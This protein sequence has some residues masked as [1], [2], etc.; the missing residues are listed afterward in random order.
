MDRI[1]IGNLLQRSKSNNFWSEW[2]WPMECGLRTIIKCESKVVGSTE[3]WCIWWLAEQMDLTL[4]IL[5]KPYN[6]KI[7]PV[8]IT[9][10][11]SQR[12][13]FPFQ[14]NLLKW[15]ENSIPCCPFSTFTLFTPVAE[16]SD[17]L[18]QLLWYLDFRFSP[19]CS[20]F[21]WWFSH[22]QLLI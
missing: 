20:R 15:M 3:M 10:K 8:K 16:W 5:S 4:K 21:R 14:G 9:A 7:S 19:K 11:F 18:E 1:S 22:L 2:L 12:Y 6:F 13:N 17:K